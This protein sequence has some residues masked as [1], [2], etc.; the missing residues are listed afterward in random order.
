MGRSGDILAGMQKEE[1]VL[2]RWS[3]SAR[4]WEK[5]RGTI[6]K[7]FAPVTEL[8]VAEAE[9]ASGQTVLDVG[10]GPGEPALSVARVVG[11]KGRVVGVDPIVE[12]VGAGRREAERQ[13]LENV[14]F[15]VA[16][17]DELPFAENA[18]DAV[19][20]RFGAMFFPAPVA[21]LR[22]LLRVTKPGRKLAF[23]V[24]HY[25]EKNPFHCAL[26]RVVDRFVEPTPLEPD[27]LD[28]FRFAEPGK[29]LGFVKEAGM[30]EATERLVRFSMDAVMTA[31]EFWT[32]RSEMSDKLRGKIGALPAE[33]VTDLKR[34][35]L[36]AFR[37]YE[38]EGGL[39]I[40]GEILVVSGKKRMQSSREVDVER[41]RGDGD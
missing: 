15:E 18:F 10:T 25:A 1:E 41:S 24:W 22:E 35:A 27:A 31:E 12:M 16:S 28:A 39:R 34:E 7:M 17:A 9:I 29:L 11:P 32:L 6:R 3:G 5:H 36:E 30:E 38:V 13:G 8:L 19:I 14:R 4:Y 23:A 33:R 37:E 2:Q 21:A 40:P 20:S 26:S